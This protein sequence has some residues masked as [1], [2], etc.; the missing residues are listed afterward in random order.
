[1]VV[2]K[3]NKSM[4]IKGPKFLIAENPLACPERIFIIHAREPVIIAEAFHFE[5]NEEKE[6]L[7]CKSNFAVGASVDYSGELIAIGAIT[8][9]MPEGNAQQQA[10]KLAAIMRR[11][12]DWYYAYLKH[13]DENIATEEDY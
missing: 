2:R 11:M 3:K 13:E 8:C 9:Q 1:M 6:W 5:E 7:R 10:D 4:G 12:G